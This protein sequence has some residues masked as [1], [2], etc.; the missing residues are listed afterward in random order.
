[1]DEKANRGKKVGR[2]SPHSGRAI[3]QRCPLP[4]WINKSKNKQEET[5]CRRSPPPLQEVEI[6]GILLTDG[7]KMRFFFFFIFSRQVYVSFRFRGM[8]DIMKKRPGEK[9]QSLVKNSVQSGI[10]LPD[11]IGKKLEKNCRSESGSLV[12]VAQS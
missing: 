8:H 12:E 6:G 9:I 7:W 11:G 1:M 10:L 5:N 3:C 2:F 4:P